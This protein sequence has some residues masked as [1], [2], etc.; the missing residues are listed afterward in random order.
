M[1]RGRIE[2]RGRSLRVRVYVGMVDD[3]QQ[4]ILE[5]VK[6]QGNKTATRNKA[7]ERLTAI[8]SDLDE[9]RLPQVGPEVTFKK[10]AERWMARGEP[11]WSPSTTAAYRSYLSIRILPELGEISIA[12]IT[13]DMLDEFYARLSADGLARATIQKIHNIIRKALSEAVRW[14]WLPYSPADRIDRRPMRTGQRR[15]PRIPA[16]NEL[17][18]LLQ[19]AHDDNQDF[20]MLLWLAAVTGARRGELCALRWGDIEGNEIHLRNVIVRGPDER[21]E[22][23][24][25][26]K[27]GTPDDPRS[28]VVL[29]DEDETVPRLRSHRLRAAERA[30]MCGLT[31]GDDSFVFSPEPGNRRAFRPVSLT[32]HFRRLRTTAKL[33]AEVHLHSLRHYV[34]SQLINGGIDVATVSEGFLGHRQKS[35]TL[36]IYTQAIKQS[37]NA[38]QAVQLITRV[39]KAAANYE[40]PPPDDAPVAT[41]A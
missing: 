34:G 6:W 38:L 3:K 9:N 27:G 36:D 31:I 24:P 19:A 23:R 37:P 13:V 12:K 28:R 22:L 21:H 35:T 26:L 29:I 25:T 8:L 4:F 32:Q 33:P 11:H 15:Q 20:E 5:T 40:P 18:L 30:M 10:L 7:E 2:Q 16:S 1:A 39:V 41:E 14:G 17:G